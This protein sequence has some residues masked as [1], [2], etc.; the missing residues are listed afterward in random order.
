MLLFLRY[1]D[2]TLD[3]PGIGDAP[4]VV[5]AVTSDIFAV[6]PRDFDYAVRVLLEDPSLLG[7]SDGTAATVTFDICE[8]ASAPPVSAIAC[9][10]ENASDPNF[11]EIPAD[12]IACTLANAE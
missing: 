9:T 1:P 7:Y 2:G 5:A 11:V 8:G 4:P 6:G 3:V 10:V 12:R